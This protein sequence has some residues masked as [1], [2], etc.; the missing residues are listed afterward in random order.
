MA[1]VD[2]MGRGITGRRQDAEKLAEKLLFTTKP[3]DKDKDNG[4]YVNVSYHP[5]DDILFM[6][7]RGGGYLI[8][9]NDEDGVLK[10]QVVHAGKD[11][12]GAQ[13]V[14]KAI[15]TSKTRYMCSMTDGGVEILGHEELFGEIPGYTNDKNIQKLI[16]AVE[17]GSYPEED[18]PSFVEKMLLPPITHL[19]NENKDFS[20]MHAG[21]MEFLSNAQGKI[22]NLHRKISDDATLTLTCI[23][24][25]K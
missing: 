21:V 16:F 25:R 17:I 11:E 3:L 8:I 23:G 13:S 22:P 7:A 9:W 19:L 12:M 1:V 10:P 15:N 24:K 4:A 18:M 14:Q 20:H 6:R 5:E 2:G